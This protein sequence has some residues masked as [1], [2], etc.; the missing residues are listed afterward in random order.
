M[1]IVRNDVKET[2]FGDVAVGS[3]FIEEDIVY[4]KTSDFYEIEGDD[5]D[6]EEERHYMYNAIGLGNG[7]FNRFSDWDMVRVSNDAHLVV[8]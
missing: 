4:M 1:K 5:C 6:Y 3:V 2:K 8:N 7:T